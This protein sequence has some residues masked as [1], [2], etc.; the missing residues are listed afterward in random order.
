MS[1]PRR[2]GL[3]A[4]GVRCRP[5]GGAAPRAR[6]MSRR[7]I[8]VSSRLYPFN[9]RLV[10]LAA[11]VTLSLLAA[12]IELPRNSGIVD[13]LN[14][15]TFDPPRAEDAA[16]P[17]PPPGTATEP[18]PGLASGEVYG[19][20]ARRAV[21]SG[22]GGDGGRARAARAEDGVT[23][24]FDRADVREVVRVV[25]GD[26]LGRNFTI[27]PQVSGEVT[28]ASTAPIMEADLLGVLESVLRGNNATLVDIGGGTFQ[29]L[30]LENAPTRAEV[31]PLG[32][33]APTLRPGYGITIVPLRNV[34]ATAAAQ[35]IQPIVTTP[36][37]IRIDTARNLLLFSGT[38]GERQSIV[39]VLADLDVNWLADKAIGLF[40]VRV[41]TPEGVI[42]EL[43]AI[44][45]PLDPSS[46]DAPLVRF[47]PLSRLNAV[48]A[49]GTNQGQIEEVGRWVDRLDRGGRAAGSQFYVYNLRHAAAEDVAKLLNEVYS[50]APGATGGGEGQAPP[51]P[52]AFSP[53][54]AAGNEGI[55][56]DISD[57]GGDA[58][59]V[60]GAAGGLP[61]SGS[62]GGPPG[63]VKVV[64]NRV[65]NSLL[66]RATPQ[67]YETIESTLLRLDT[68]PLQVLVEATIVEVLLNDA[69][70]YGV[71]YF[72]KSGGLRGGFNSG[73]DGDGEFGLTPS[74][75]LP[76][77]NFILA[78][79]SSNVTIDALARLT[80]VKVLSS[81]SVVVQDNS[82]AT[83]TVGDEVP[84]VTRQSQ[85]IE[86]FDSPLLNN[87]EYR[88]TGVILKVKP[89][90]NQNGVV[91]LEIAQE[92]SRVSD[93]SQGSAEG[94]LTPTITQRKITSRVNVQNGQTVA[95][96]GLIQDSETRGRDRIPILGEIPVLGN[97]FGTT[98]TSNQRTELIVFLTPRVVR[99][100]GDARNVSEEL[101]ARLKSLRPFAPEAALPPVPQPTRQRPRPPPAAPTPRT[102][103]LPQPPQ[104]PGAP[105][106]LVP[107]GTFGQAAPTPRGPARPRAVAATPS[108]PRVPAGA[109]AATASPTQRVPV[110]ANAAAASPAP[111]EPIRPRPV[112]A[113][114]PTTTEAAALAQG[115]P[116]E[117][118]P[119]LVGVRAPTREVRRAPAGAAPPPSA[120][121]ALVEVAAASGDRAARTDPTLAPAPVPRARPVHE[122]R[123]PPSSRPS[124]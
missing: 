9:A 66:I 35:F 110:R 45:G 105:Q 12:C 65:N 107:E 95:L 20:G 18:A 123:P 11:A 62:G 27:D 71:Q 119:E 49:V 29:I 43:Q 74:A 115:V 28:L 60:D 116:E 37:D 23:L 13:S 117:W 122:V 76:G 21:T 52:G 7:L 59:Q 5:H 104:E 77:F 68:P 25:L 3:S 33:R 94:E 91:N 4:L 8:Q 101:R 50:D 108:P 30:P 100:A 103:P 38:Q 90:I 97:L 19:G 17:T 102:A 120:V 112:A 72:A 31:A 109:R 113:T 81:P 98:D 36:E 22:A 80:D 83:L 106:I 63:G 69:L 61:S 93:A 79:G 2:G 42:A 92:V 86:D 51:G 1:E 84:I 75:I 111:R 16:V 47:V 67:A 64:A 54:A 78:A 10:P 99:D 40:P 6:R 44:F 55:E 118:L 34:S 53:D 124:G 82:E 26:V 114:S 121:P 96:G 39:D 58:A 89:R 70:R 15:V 85:S 87:I 46:A 14:R 24:N 32:G 41:A 48:L 73:T 56:E 57:D 88:N